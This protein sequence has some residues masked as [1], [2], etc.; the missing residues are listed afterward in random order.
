MENQEQDN[1][2]ETETKEEVNTN[3]LSVKR[4]LSI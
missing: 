4:V 1:I 2:K 3:R